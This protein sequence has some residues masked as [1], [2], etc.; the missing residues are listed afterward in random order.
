MPQAILPFAGAFAGAGVLLV[1]LVVAGCAHGRLLQHALSLGPRGVGR[2]PNDG[3]GRG[4][5]RLLGDD[6]AVLG[7][8]VLNDVE[9]LGQSRSG[10]GEQQSCSDNVSTHGILLIG[11]AQ[12]RSWTASSTRAA[13]PRPTV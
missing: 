9:L 7:R 10:Q 13:H 8:G 11:S 4:G 2:S 1:L 12:R 3:G 5:C 6:G